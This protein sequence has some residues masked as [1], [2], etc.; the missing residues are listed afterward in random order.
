MNAYAHFVTS[1][2]SQI[3]T[4]SLKIH[5]PDG[6]TLHAGT[7]PS[8]KSATLTIHNYDFFRKVA[9]GRD[10]GFGESYVDGD[11]DTPDLTRLLSL[12]VPNQQTDQLP[13]RMTNWIQSLTNRMHHRA[14]KNTLRGSRKNI[15]AHYDLSNPF[16]ALFLDPSM[17]YSCGCFSGEKESLEQAQLHKFNRMLDRIQPQPT[18]HVLEIG[19][20]WGSFA[21]HAAQRT[22]CKVTGLT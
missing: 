4:G 7:G 10:I 13:N 5:M 21:I 12:F 2:L 15:Q 20:G 1:Y 11:F 14:R 22:G 17:T 18:D 6:S 9:R 19:C 16:Y 8:G 3:K